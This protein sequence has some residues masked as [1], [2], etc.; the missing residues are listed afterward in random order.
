MSCTVVDWRRGMVVTRQSMT[1]LLD[2]RRSS[3]V[4]RHCSI[5]VK[6]QKMIE[7]AD[8]RANGVLDG[9]N[10]AD[11]SIDGMVNVVALR[12]TSFKNQRCGVYSIR[13]KEQ[14]GVTIANALKPDCSVT[15]GYGG[16]PR[17]RLCPALASAPRSIS[18]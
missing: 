18:A 5:G 8:K 2:R 17:A 11:L 13:L 6:T 14:C 1:T 9:A 12:N 10:L 3:L 15:M 7:F 16:D 4:V